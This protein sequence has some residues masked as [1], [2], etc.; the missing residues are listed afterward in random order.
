MKQIFKKLPLS[1][2]FTLSITFGFAQQGLLFENHKT[3]KQVMIKEGD[4]VKFNYNGYIKQKETKYG[5]VLSIQDSVI[6]IISPTAR[7]KISLEGTE[8]RFIYINDI[9]GFR[10]F[11]RSRPYLMA[12]STISITIG[13]VYVYYMIDKKT[14][15]NFGEK[16]GLS[17]GT[18]L[19]STIIVRSLFPERI[20]NN[21]GENWSLK[22]LK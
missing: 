19:L 22:V 16:L 11:H 3:K 7:G 2:L 14:N 1:F 12:L 15:L 13:S 18:G 4:L 21:I 9:T 10:K 20:K 5:V 8:I 6:E 17:L